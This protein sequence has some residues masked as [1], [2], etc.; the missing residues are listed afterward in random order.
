MDRVQF[1]SVKSV[2][3]DLTLGKRPRVDDLPTLLNLHQGRFVEADDNRVMVYFHPNVVHVPNL[4]EQKPGNQSQPAVVE[5]LEQAKQD[6]KRRWFV[7]R[8]T[9][10][11]ASDQ[12]QTPDAVEYGTYRFLFFIHSHRIDTD[13]FPFQNTVYTVSI[14]DREVSVPLRGSI[15]CICRRLSQGDL[16]S[17][18][19]ITNVNE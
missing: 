16:K 1:D 10:R 15:A 9:Y 11:A 2:L 12:Q 6:L 17:Y 19:S 8:K 5:I 7:L 18:L 14:W 13:R 4:E 3:R